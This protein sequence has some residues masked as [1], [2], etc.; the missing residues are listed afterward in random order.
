[1]IT[2]PSG[3]DAF[4]WDTTFTAVGKDAVFSATPAKSDSDQRSR[5]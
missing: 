4:D 5:R 2:Q 1:V 3:N